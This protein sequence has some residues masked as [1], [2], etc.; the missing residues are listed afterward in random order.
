[1]TQ[2]R[3]LVKSATKHVFPFSGSH[4]S[5]RNENAFPAVL[6]WWAGWMQKMESR[7][8]ERRARQRSGKTRW[9][10]GQAMEPKAKAKWM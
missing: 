2:S 1:M 4:S 8:P 10:W 7:G 9:G 6:P 5:R 3:F